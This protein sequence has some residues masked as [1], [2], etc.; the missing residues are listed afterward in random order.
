MVIFPL[1]Q[2]YSAKCDCVVI[3]AVNITD[4]LLEAFNGI[5]AWLDTLFQDENY[6]AGTRFR[7]LKCVQSRPSLVPTSAVQCL[8]STRA[9][10]YRLNV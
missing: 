6:I 3:L 9:K 4:F 5:L 2:L 7:R 10:R 8:V 1:R